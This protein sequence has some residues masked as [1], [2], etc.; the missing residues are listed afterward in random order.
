[1]ELSWSTFVLEIINFL[2]LVWILKRFFYKPVLN[3]IAKRR[4][5]IDDSLSSAKALHAD[6]DKLRKQYEGRLADWEQERQQARTTLNQELDAE[7]AKKMALLQTEL[8]QEREKTRVVEARQQA[9]AMREME[10]TALKQ[11]ARFASRLLA[12]ASG[13]ETETNLVDL[14]ITELSRLPPERITAL[15]NSYGE[16]PDTALVV[17]AH[18][19]SDNQRQQLEQVLMTVAGPKLK[20]QFEQ[21]SELL[22][23]V[24]ISLGA[25][26]LGA[27][28]Q[29]EL[30]GFSALAH[31]E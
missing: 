2:I 25:W 18:P 9:V 16:A 12:Q 4:A 28:F 3:V 27:N 31:E 5:E 10:E 8:E 15:R 26:V 7:R 17:S 21:N 24:R 6:A 19:L 29:D 22:A 13:A 14:V 20:V 23:G 1:L 30:E 11:A